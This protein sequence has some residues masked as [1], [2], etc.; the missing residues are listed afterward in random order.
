MNEPITD[1]YDNWFP[2]V[3]CTSYSLDNFKNF[4][5]DKSLSVFNVNIRSSRRN[6][7]KLESLLT[8][9]KHISSI[10]LL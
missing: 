5:P 8:M 2:T 9:T 1:N 3:L 7:T 6:F 4:N 10:L